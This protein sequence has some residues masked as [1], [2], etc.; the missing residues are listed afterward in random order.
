MACGY[1]GEVTAYI[2]LDGA[3]IRPLEVLFKPWDPR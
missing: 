1:V 3:I 2:R